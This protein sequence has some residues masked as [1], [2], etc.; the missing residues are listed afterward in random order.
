MLR[1][2]FVP[3]FVLVLTFGFALSTR[4]GV[5]EIYVD[6]F[7]EEHKITFYYET[8]FEDVEIGESPDGWEPDA[9]CWRTT[10]TF[11]K[12]DGLNAKPDWRVD[13]GG[14]NNDQNYKVL[15]QANDDEEHNLGVHSIIQFKDVKFR[16]VVVDY[17]VMLM[18]VGYGEH[19]GL[20]FRQSAADTYLRVKFLGRMRLL[21]LKGPVDPLNSRPE[22]R[23]RW[24]SSIPYIVPKAF[25][26]WVRVEA[27]EKNVTVWISTDGEK[28]ELL[29]TCSND[30]ILMEPGNVSLYAGRRV[31]FDW[32]R[33]R[34]LD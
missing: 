18:D 27:I 29:Y 16:D 31:H 26:Y 1:K 32:V 21:Q 15:A 10:D 30:N 6:V 23:L 20:I 24:A 25:Y 8:D 28:Y 2:I 7:G 14:A 17:K 5:G 22:E 12:V 33:I 9:A 11:A 13:W 3:V 19:T 34:G 4:A